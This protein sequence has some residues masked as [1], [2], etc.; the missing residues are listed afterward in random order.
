MHR[1]AFSMKIDEKRCTV[2]IFPTQTM[3]FVVLS[4]FLHK[5]SM[6]TVVLSGF[7]IE[8]DKTVAL[9]CVSLKNKENRCAVM[10]FQTK[11]LKIVVL[12]P[13]FTHDR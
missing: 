2:T 9:S 12:S 6:E 13:L 5:K 10:R 4:R 3:E 1:R 7:F 11:S 8:D